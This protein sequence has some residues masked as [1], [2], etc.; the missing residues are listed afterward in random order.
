MSGRACRWQIGS[1]PNSG[2]LSCG[3]WLYW[4]KA[5]GFTGRHAAS[6]LACLAVAVDQ[7]K[8]IWQGWHAAGGFVG[9]HAAC[10][11]LGWHMTS[12]FYWLASLAVAVEQP[13]YFWQGWHAACSFLGWPR[14]GRGEQAAGLFWLGW[15]A[16]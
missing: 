6:G 16:A 1:R 10:G 15:H 3:Q 8:L 5:N 4:R 13:Y 7:P 2:G 11:V 14:D 9:W 12:G